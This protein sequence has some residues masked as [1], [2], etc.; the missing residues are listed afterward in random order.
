MEL[1][2]MKKAP[3]VTQMRTRLVTMEAAICASCH[4]Q[5]IKPKGEPFCG[6]CLDRM[7]DE[8]EKEIREST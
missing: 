8:Y 5:C 2:T 7:Y 1:Q 4:N 6:S 3:V